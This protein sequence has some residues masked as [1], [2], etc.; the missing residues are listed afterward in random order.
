MDKEEDNN[1]EQFSDEKSVT[2]ESLVFNSYV[3]N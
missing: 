2:F 3:N 1:E